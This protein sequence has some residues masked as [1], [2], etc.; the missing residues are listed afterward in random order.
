[1][2]GRSSV[3]AD[4]DGEW[5]CVMSTPMGEQKAVLSVRSAGATFAG[6]MSGAQGALDVIDGRV[7]GDRLSW[8]MDLSSPMKML[9]TCTATVSGDRIE[10]GVKAGIF[11]TSP[12]SGTRK[13]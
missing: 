12:L 3:V 1:M 6:R 9:L 13:R 7:D 4:V 11:G 8:K 2:S 10:G 5:D